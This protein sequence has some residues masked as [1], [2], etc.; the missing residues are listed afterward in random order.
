[1]SMATKPK[2]RFPKSDTHCICPKEESIGSSQNSHSVYR[3]KC[4]RY[5]TYSSHT[6]R[7]LKRDSKRFKKKKKK[8]PQNGP[9][10]AEVSLHTRE[11]SVKSSRFRIWKVKNRKGSSEIQQFETQLQLSAQN[12]GPRVLQDQV[13]FHA[14]VGFCTKISKRKK[15]TNKKKSFK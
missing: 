11:K 5:F 8:Q 7:T 1:M 2:H 4:Q 3:G 10:N 14:I 15:E 6:H 9:L 13:H 12:P